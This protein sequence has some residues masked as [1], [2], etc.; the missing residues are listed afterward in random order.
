LDNERRNRL[1]AEPLRRQPLDRENVEETL[2]VQ[3]RN[4]HDQ[5]R[6]PT[7]NPLLPKVPY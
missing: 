3:G 4:I 7:A 5:H 1:K 6:F 2:F